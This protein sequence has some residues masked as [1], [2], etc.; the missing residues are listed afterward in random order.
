MHDDS[1]IK[2]TVIDALNIYLFFLFSATILSQTHTSHAAIVYEIP[3][4]QC[5]LTLSKALFDKNFKVR[6]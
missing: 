1:H 2:H 4:V 5:D 6:L 3:E